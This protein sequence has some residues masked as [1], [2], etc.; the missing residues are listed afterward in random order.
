MSDDAKPTGKAAGGF[1]RAEAL[2]SAQRKAIAKAAAEK[3]WAQATAVPR[4]AYG[5]PDRPLRI[6]D[7]EIPCYVL[8]DGRRVLVQRGLQS[9][10]GMSTSGGTGGA[11]R[12]AQFLESLEA[13]GLEIGDL[14]VRIRAPIVFQPEGFVKPAYGYEATILPDICDAVLDAD[15]RGLLVPQQAHFAAQCRIL[16]KALSRVGIIALVDEATGYQ[17]VRPQDALEQY[18]ALIVRKE[19]AAWV[20]KFPD[21]FYEN[22]YKLHGWTWPGMGKNRYSVVA[23][24]TRDLVYERMAPGLLE[25]LEKKTPKNEKGQ[26][27][28]LMKDWLSAD[29]GDPM[30]AQHLHSLIMFQRLA[31][32]SGYGWK[33]LAGGRKKM[34]VSQSWRPSAGRKK[35]RRG[36]NGCAP[37]K[38]SSMARTGRRCPATRR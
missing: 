23:H 12:L 10:I 22:I 8:D 27:T 24:Y 26:R 36:G 29:V 5:S 31:I 7:A 35:R 25:E 4:S 6:G 37:S 32:K 14:A 3:R 13:K 21:E 28:S 38:S 33:R 2:T 15:E 11:H 9:G 18:L 20:K 34:P 1:A 19:L 17:G 30:L 16:R